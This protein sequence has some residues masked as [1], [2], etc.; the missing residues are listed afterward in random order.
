MRI[1]YIDYSIATKSLD[2]F[3]SGCLKPYCEGC[4]NPELADFN[5]GTNY[6]EWLDKIEEYLNNYGDIIENIFLLGGSLNHQNTEDVDWFFMHLFY[7]IQAHQKI[8][9]FARED[10]KDIRPSFYVSCD[11]IK[12]GEYIPSLTCDNNI[13]Y[14]IKLATSNQNI[15]KRGVDYRIGDHRE[16][17]LI[18][19]TEEDTNS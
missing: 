16:G 11:Y 13:Q 5:V 2:I 4:C 14:G 7:G 1:S 18:N 10:L 17:F 6:E 8:W 15:Y 19:E 12:C 3:F 9:L